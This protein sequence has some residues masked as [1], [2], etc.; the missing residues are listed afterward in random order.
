ML[1][2]LGC[3]E[4]PPKTAP[5]SNCG[6]AESGLARPDLGVRVE[7]LATVTGFSCYRWCS[8]GTALDGAAGFRYFGAEGT[9]SGGAVCTRW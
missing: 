2:W 4:N 3:A 5:T 6:G 7:G 9:E 8:R 1:S